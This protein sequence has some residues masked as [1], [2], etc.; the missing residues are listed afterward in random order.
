MVNYKWNGN[1]ERDSG[2][3][4]IGKRLKEKL[5]G[6]AF[7]PGTTTKLPAVKSPEYKPAVRDARR[8]WFEAIW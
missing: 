3:Y 6:I 4:I 7:L 5:D 2:V 8:A 1:G